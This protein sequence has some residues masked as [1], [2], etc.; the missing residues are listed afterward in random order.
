[1]K[2]I[3]AAAPVRTQAVEAIRAEI[4]SGTLKPGQRLVERELCERLDVSRNTVRE[5][6]R[7]LEAEGF[8]VIPPHKGPTVAQLSDEEA[9][10]IYEVREALECFAVRLFV[11]R[12]SDETVTRLRDALAK[13]KAAHESGRVARMLSTKTK[14]YDVLY[15]GAGNEVLHSQAHLL[16]GRLAQLRARSLSHS[17]RPQSSIAEIEEVVARIAARDADAASALWRDHIRNAAATALSR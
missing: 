5:A 16:H 15:S 14:F 17:G 2:V 1:M 10:A 8:L 3:H 9:R 4:V 11:E 7:Q 6:C 13:L 12:A